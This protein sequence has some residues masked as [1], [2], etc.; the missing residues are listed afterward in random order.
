PELA[1]RT[2]PPLLPRLVRG[3][4]ADGTLSLPDGA[5]WRLTTD[6]RGSPE[7]ITA[8]PAPEALA[9]LGKGEV[10]IAVR[11]AGL[12]FHDVIAALGLDPDPEQQ[13]LGSEGA[14]TVVEVGPGVDDL[15]PGDRVMG[16]FGD[17]F[18]PTAV[19]D[20]RTVARIPAGWSFARAASVPVVFLT[21]YYG[22]FDLGGLRR[23][24]A[25]LVHAGAGGVGMAA[26]QLAR[27][28]GA[29]VFAT[30]S[31]AKWDVLRAGGLD[32]AHIASTRTTDFAE[33]FLT[34]TGG[35]GVDLVLDS[36][37]REFVD[38]GLRLLPNGGRFVEMGKTDI[39]DPEA[40]ARQYPGVRY[41]AFDLMEAGPER[42]G[43]MLTDVLR[44][45]ERGALRPLPVTGW[46]VRQAPAALRSLSR[47]RGVGKN[48]L[49]LPTPPD[50]EGT[51]LVTGATGTL[52]R[53][54]A[55]HLVVAHGIRHLL[56]AGRRGGSADGMP[57]LVRELTGLGASVTVA[58]C[59][60]A[61]RA[62]LAAL[63]GSVDAAHPLTAV[64]HAAGVLDDATVTGLTPDRLDR[65]LRPKADAA[66]ALHELTR[67]LDLEALVLFSSGAAQ[68]GA[69]GQANYAAANAVLD[70]LAAERR[71]EGLPGLSIGWG[72]WEERSGMTAGVTEGRGT[73]A[74]ALTSAEGLALF[75]AALDS[76]Y[77]YRLAAR[78]APSALRADD[79]LPA[80]LRGLA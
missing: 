9:P 22:L 2:G 72:L 11:A 8:E 51:V 49:L 54:L 80:V 3:G 10:R 20:R 73:G 77:A 35:R 66:L 13:G 50:P 40:V 58:A 53:L 34:A 45:F 28:A 18:G 38:A 64:V 27:H 36:L 56:L 29:R 63:L 78:I 43:E 19:A 67:D 25:V 60:A 62:A 70:A 48:V 59:D 7:D 75:D 1:L 16:I 30:A 26:V 79:W 41:R 44:L 37:A 31:P 61:D 5:A 46:D 4:R 74:G 55:R 57:E 33:K 52:G 12:N 17:A 14:G 42:I 71:A 23:G 39:R 15:V 32:D 47:A 24:E 68:F 76:P 65:V 21:A 6:G 69:A